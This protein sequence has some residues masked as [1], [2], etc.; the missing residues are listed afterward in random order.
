[1]LPI[2]P[3]DVVLYL[4]EYCAFD[5][6]LN[7]KRTCKFYY[8]ILTCN[9]IQFWKRYKKWAR[10]SRLDDLDND[11]VFSI[12]KLGRRALEKIKTSCPL[13]LRTKT[14]LKGQFIYFDISIDSI[15]IGD[16]VFRIHADT[17]NAEVTRSH[18]LTYKTSQ[19]SMQASKV[20]L[21]INKMKKPKSEDVKN[22]YNWLSRQLPTQILVQIQRRVPQPPTPQPIF[23][24]HNQPTTTTTTKDFY[25]EWTETS[26]DLLENVFTSLGVKCKSLV[27]ALDVATSSEWSM[28]FGKNEIAAWNWCTALIK[29][30]LRS[31]YAEYIVMENVI[32]IEYRIFNGQNFINDIYEIPMSLDVF[33]E[34][35]IYYFLPQNLEKMLQ[36][37]AHFEEIPCQKLENEY[38]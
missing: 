6:L 4:F 36:N 20:F 5:D 32:P 15:D 24:F 38:I 23:H 3:L 12:C 1:M 37:P 27:E 13:K 22:R 28:I 26:E 14:G 35:Y 25:I 31:K 10:S 9:E 16:A 8:R 2:L 29:R 21:K 11:E 18:Y 33:N 19:L 30:S 34:K 17:L 7:L